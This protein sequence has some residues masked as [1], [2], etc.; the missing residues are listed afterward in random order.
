MKPKDRRA[1]G[2]YLRWVANAMGLRDWTITVLHDPCDEDSLG[3]CNPTYGR[4]MADISFPADFR[5]S[6]TP[7]GQ[8][9]T[10]V[11][12]LLHCVFAAEQDHIRIHLPR[13]LAQSTYDV[14]NDTYRQ[15]HEY[16]IDGLA[17]ALA[18]HMPLIQWPK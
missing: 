17:D 11:H 6:V 8:R 1:L 12:E 4:K 10:V 3:V 7:E 16:A 9:Q 18:P 5:H 15:M 13:H 2:R 14:F